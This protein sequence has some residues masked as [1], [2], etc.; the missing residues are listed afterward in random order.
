MKRKQ[1][2]YPGRKQIKV[3]GE[4]QIFG[5]GDGVYNRG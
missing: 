1:I 5:N 2:S 3:F 4:K